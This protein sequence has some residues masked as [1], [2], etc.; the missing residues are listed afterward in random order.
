MKYLT[1]KEAAETLGYASDA[2]I[3]RLIKTKDINAH[4]FGKSWAIP[5]EELGNIKRIRKQYRK[6]K[7]S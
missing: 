6:R 7:S 1:T 3:R 5:E 4:K 2:V